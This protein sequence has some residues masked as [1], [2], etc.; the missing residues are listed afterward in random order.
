MFKNIVLIAFV[1]LAS[2][3]PL[4]QYYCGFSGTYCGQSSNDDTNL[5]ASLII[6]AFANIL[7]NGTVVMD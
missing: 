1:A 7:P 4:A 2:C 3:D 5:N 6:L